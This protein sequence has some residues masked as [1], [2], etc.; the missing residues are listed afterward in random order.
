MT[1]PCVNL[2]QAVI[3]VLKT[4]GLAPDCDNPSNWA[5]NETQQAALTKLHAELCSFLPPLPG[6][7]EEIGDGV[8][9]PPGVRLWVEASFSLE[10]PAI[11]HQLDSLAQKEMIGEVLCRELLRYPADDWSVAA[12]DRWK[13]DDE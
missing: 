6:A 1:E 5:G 2:V 10:V 13:V 12:V 3:G 4:H 8:P 7:A 11:Y 9:P